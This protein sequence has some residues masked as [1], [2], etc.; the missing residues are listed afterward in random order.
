VLSLEPDEFRSYVRMVR[1]VQASMGVLDLVPSTVD[2]AE[3]PKWF[4]HLVATRPLSRGTRLTEDM[5]DGKRPEAGVSP[6]HLLLFVGRVLK[7]DL[8]ADEAIG[9]DDV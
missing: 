9:W 1:D 3:R 8:K 2:L 6:E 5:L 7:R 4:R